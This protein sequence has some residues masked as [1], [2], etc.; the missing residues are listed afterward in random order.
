MRKTP[1]AALLLFPLII[2]CAAEERASFF[3]M[4]TLVEL[5]ALGGEDAIE[6]ARRAVEEVERWAD[7]YDPAA[8][9]S[10]LNGRAGGGPVA[11][12]PELAALLALSL[13]VA[14][15]SGGAFDPTVEPLLAA[16]DFGGEHQR[17]PGEEELRELLARVDYRRVRLAGDSVEMPEGFAVDLGGVAKGYAA[18]RALEAMRRAGARAGLVNIGGDIAVFGEKG[19]GPWTIGIQHPRAPGG[20]FAVLELD[21]GAVATSGDYER[22]FIAEGV[23]YHHLLDPKTGRP[24]RGLVSATVTA[25]NCT[26]ADA[27]ATAVFVLGPEEGPALLAA[28]DR[29]EGI[30]IYEDEGGLGY[31]MTEGLAGRL[32]V[33]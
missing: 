22:F 11:V 13:E 21:G 19:G 32:H 3:A 1:Q 26:L 25:P 23:R 31:F 12:S 14:R 29:L 10:R 4:D 27:Y 24:A 15:A 7:R 9:V 2:A 30:F 8:E 18:D 33:Y 16:Y 28:D 20:L 17:V 6:E 5:I